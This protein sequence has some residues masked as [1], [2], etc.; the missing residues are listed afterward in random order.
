[1]PL[2]QKSKCESKECISLRA[3]RL[4]HYDIVLP[5][6]AGHHEHK[7]DIV[8]SGV[9]ACLLC[10]SVH[11]CGNN[12]TNVE[13]VNDGVIC[14]ITGVYVHNKHYVEEY[15]ENVHMDDDLR[16]AV[17]QGISDRYVDIEG[18]VNYLLTSAIAQRAFVR[19]FQRWTASRKIEMESTNNYVEKVFKCVR[20]RQPGLLKYD[21]H[22][23]KNLAK[24]VVILLNHVLSM[25]MQVLRLEIKEVDFFGFVAGICY[26]M[27]TGVY[28]SGY[29]V[30]PCSTEM[31]QSLP[32]ESSLVLFD[33]IKAKNITDAENRFKFVLRNVTP[34]FLKQQGLDVQRHWTHPGC[35]PQ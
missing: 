24:R 29:E 31:I 28:I 15:S 1:M 23:R 9:A 14:R 17:Y 20:I 22:A 12:C 10:G 19:D 25:L 3:W 11:V 21:I 13:E 32:S 35:R 27:K 34:E 5:P 33:N 4:L 2:L 7:W 30:L 18:C 6:S 16:V 26:L 8:D